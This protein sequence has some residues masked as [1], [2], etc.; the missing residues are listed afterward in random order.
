M[1]PVPVSERANAGLFEEY[2]Q[3]WLDNPDSVDPTWRAFFQ[4]FTLG[5][6]GGS[7][8]TGYTATCGTQNASSSGSPI[9]VM[10]LANGVAVTC[11][12]VANNAHGSSVP[13]PASNSVTPATVPDAPVIG[14]AIPGNTEAFI[15]FTPPA[16]NGGSVITGYSAICNPGGLSGTGSVSP[17]TVWNRP[18][19]SSSI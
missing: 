5:S 9:V 3:R 7:P 14:T 2:Y 1:N 10:G 16:S 18:S 13:S 8:I 19:A 15:S 17:I 11:R 6:N 4:G 12:V